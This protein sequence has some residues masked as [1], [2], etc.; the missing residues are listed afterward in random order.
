MLDWEHPDVKAAREKFE[1]LQRSDLQRA[2]EK[3]RLEIEQEQYATQRAECAEAERVNRWH[4]T[5]NAA[6]TGLLALGT[7]AE[8]RISSNYHDSIHYAADRYAS[9]AHGPLVKP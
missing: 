1:A 4:A 8:D 7:R 6:L 3:R 5:Y 2:H 9:R